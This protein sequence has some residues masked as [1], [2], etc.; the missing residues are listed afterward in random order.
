M[1]IIAA[2]LKVIESQK[3]LGKLA[4]YFDFMVRSE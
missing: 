4:D 3:I 2:G 1:F